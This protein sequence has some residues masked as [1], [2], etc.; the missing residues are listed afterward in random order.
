MTLKVF[1]IASHPLQ[2]TMAILSASR[3][4][5]SMYLNERTTK[6]NIGR[7]HPPIRLLLQLVTSIL[8]LNRITTEISLFT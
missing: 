3:I 6:L 5:V 4:P 8:L 7:L 2:S 1:Y